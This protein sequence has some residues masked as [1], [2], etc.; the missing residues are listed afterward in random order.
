L[1][2]F[3]GL[4]FLVF[5]ILR[6]KGSNDAAQRAAQTERGKCSVYE[7][8]FETEFAGLK[9]R[10]ATST[11]SAEWKARLSDLLDGA[12]AQQ[13]VA[14]G[15][16]SGLNRSSNNP[17]TPRLSQ[18]AYADMAQ[19][20]ANVVAVY[21]DADR[22]L[23][24]VATEFEKAKRGEPISSARYEGQKDPGAQQARSPSGVPPEARRSAP[25]SS[26]RSVPAQPP[27]VVHHHH[28]GN[29]NDGLLTGVIIGSVMSDH[30]RHDDDYDRG[31]AAGRA[32]E[33]DD[34]GPVI[35][36]PQAPA[37]H[38][39]GGERTVEA[40]GDGGGGER[41]TSFSGDGGGGTRGGD[42]TPTRSESTWGGGNN[43]SY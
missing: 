1:I 12:Q 13:G 28:D 43:T 40:S 31:V 29:S 19:R 3:G 22:R 35:Y 2:L 42:D 10:I 9:A 41:V 6:K 11:V 18:E 5:F 7:N 25:R 21:E 24:F 27:T 26:G 16:L 15:Q 23:K 30:H 14:S 33:R 38:E 17:D 4:V 20:Y 32:R 36:E 34:S 8:G 39:G 37:V